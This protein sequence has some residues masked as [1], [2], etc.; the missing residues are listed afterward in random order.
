MTTVSRPSKDDLS[1]SLEGKI[2]LATGAASGIGLATA[3]LF[4]SHG[5]K[6]VIA[7]L[8]EDR[9][10]DAAAKI[11]PECKHYQCNVTSWSEQL[12]MFQWVKDNIGSPDIVFCNAG[13]DL[14]MKAIAGDAH[15]TKAG[16][17]VA[18]NY[19]VDEVDEGSSTLKAP[20]STIIDVNFWGVL[21]GI[22]LATHYMRKASGGRIIVTGSANSYW[23]VPA[24]NM[25]DAS[26]HAVLGLMRSTAQRQE[27][28]A[29][30]ITVSMLS[31]SFTATPMT[32]ILTE[33][34][35]TGIKMSEPEDV[36]WAVAYMATAPAEAVNG[37]TINVKGTE[38]RE[39]EKSY[40]GWA[41]PIFEG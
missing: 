5:A 3:K 2:L 13:V 33:E 24:M 32:S 9:L 27:L 19:L 18:Y 41:A 6:V 23:A 26:K 29:A 25:Y 7:D 15:E 8:G 12:G 11:G 38:L 21:Y 39:V 10:K 30:R 36:A 40:H 20:A 31:P 14:E 37:C 34:S 4:Y 28:S 16:E 22:K 17:K 35:T 1:K